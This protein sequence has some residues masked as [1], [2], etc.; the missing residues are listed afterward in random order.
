MGASPLIPSLQTLLSQATE[1]KL[2]F[3]SEE[4]V[5]QLIA[6]IR[7]QIE[8]LEKDVFASFSTSPYLERYGV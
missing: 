5:R 6:H 4:S 8:G 3:C 2:R 1:A 7:R